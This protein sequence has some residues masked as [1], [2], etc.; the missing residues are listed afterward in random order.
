[1]DL[2]FKRYASPFLFING[3][4]QTSR[5]TEFVENLIATSNKEKEE[6]HLWRYFL[7]VRMQFY[8]GS[9]DDFRESLKNDRNNA[10]LSVDDIETTI[11]NSMNILQNFN[12]EQKG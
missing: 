3:M 5:F 6:E 2:L 8:E 10:A 7:S 11:Q 9:F 1:M 12:P 4:I